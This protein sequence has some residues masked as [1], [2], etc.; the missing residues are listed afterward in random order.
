MGSIRYKVDK[1]FDGLETERKIKQYAFRVEETCS[2]IITGRISGTTPL[3]LLFN[4][5]AGL[6]R[7]V[8]L[9]GT[10]LLFSSLDELSGW[11]QACMVMLKVKVL[12]D[13]VRWEKR[14]RRE[15]VRKAGRVRKTRK[16]FVSL[17][18]FNRSIGA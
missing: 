3:G 14:G 4:I 6:Y 8:L 7:R 12:E 13:E 15:R 1:D 17:C 11:Y 16:N 2:A 10:V 9:L 5:Q 18:S